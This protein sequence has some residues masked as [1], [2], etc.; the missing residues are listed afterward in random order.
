MNETFNST[1]AGA[2]EISLN[3]VLPLDPSYQAKLKTIS[4]RVIAIVLTDWNVELFFLPDEHQITVLSSYEGKPNVKLMGKSWDFF[5]MGISQFIDESE[6]TSDSGIHFEGDVA[7]GQKFEQ[8]FKGLN[9]DWEEALSDVTGDIFAHQAAH[10][11]KKAGAWFKE[12]FENTQ[13]NLGEYVQEELR[14]TPT[15]IEVENFFDDLS[16]LENRANNLIERFQNTHFDD[17]H[18]V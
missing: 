7:T 2:V 9:I 5:S 18:R 4:G 1:L 12:I 13:D 8:L 11:A 17:Q 14:L 6:M 16:E 15:K 10:I 3:R